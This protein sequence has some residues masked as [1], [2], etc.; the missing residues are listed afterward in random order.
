VD[1]AGL[2]KQIAEGDGEAF[3]AFYR[4]CA[5]RIRSFLRHYLAHQQAAEDVMQDTFTEIWRRPR[6][7][8]SRRGSLRAYVFGI[9]RKQAA[10]W[11]RRQR[12][13]QEAESGEP[14]VC[15][16]EACSLVADAF[17]HLTAEQRLLLWLR[18]VE[19]H[20]YNELASI[21]EIP[22][23]TVRSRLFCAREALRTIWREVPAAKGDYR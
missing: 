22:V 21:L 5:P 7:Y 3:D 1:D 16:T 8:D 18:E 9:A 10:E 12:P 19:G 2:W 17:S 11:W 23:G 6:G 4:E 15:A 20:S 14:G 13:E